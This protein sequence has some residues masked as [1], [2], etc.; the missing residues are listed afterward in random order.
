MTQPTENLVPGQAHLDKTKSPQQADMASSDLRYFINQAFIRRSQSQRE[1]AIRISIFYNALAM[2]VLP[3]AGKPTL[4]KYFVMIHGFVFSIGLVTLFKTPIRDF[5]LRFAIPIF[6]LSPSLINF[7]AAYYHIAENDHIRTI[8]GAS[9]A[10]ICGGFMSFIDP[11]SANPRA[12]SALVCIVVGF[13]AFAESPAGGILAMVNGVATGGS[14]FVTLIHDRDFRTM[15]EREYKL[16]VQAAPAKIVRESASSNIDVDKVFEPKMRHCVCLSSDWRDYQ[17]VSASVSAESLAAALG[18]YYDMWERLLGEIFPEGNYYSDWIA[19]EFFLVIFAKDAEEEKRLVNLALKFSEK[20]IREKEIFQ[21][22]NGVPAAIDIG[23]SSGLALIGMMGPS[24]HRKATALGE[25]PGQARR[26][27]VVGKAIRQTL[28]D[29]DR[30]I[31][32]ATTLM[33]ITEALAV[34]EFKLED[35]KQLRNMD[36]TSVFYLEPMKT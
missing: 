35:K 10:I 36:G 8:M 22:A 21:K 33:E 26:L 28:G 16:L 17:K 11:R 20:I 12:F 27:Q 31:F 15:T 18:R 32:G 13:L 5:L 4:A 29:T 19:D 23:V 3:V 24:G 6:L 7:Y 2:A 34:Q 9:T 30:I 25:V 1:L 14:F